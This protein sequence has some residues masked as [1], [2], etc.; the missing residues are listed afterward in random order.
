[1][2]DLFAPQVDEAERRT[3]AARDADRRTA[4]AAAPRRTFDLR[5]ESGCGNCAAWRQRR[6][7]TVIG[8]CP[9]RGLTSFAGLCPDH[10]P[11]G[12]AHA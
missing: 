1:M 7:S 11:K 8:L 2:T 12:Q 5:G 3:Q 9:T 4:G 6:D 10:S